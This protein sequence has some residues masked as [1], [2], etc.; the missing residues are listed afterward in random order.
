MGSRRRNRGTEKYVANKQARYLGMQPEEVLGLI[1][2]KGGDYYRSELFPDQAVMEQAEGDY[3][4][5][6]TGTAPMNQVADDMRRYYGVGGSESQVMLTNL[7]PEIEAQVTAVSEPFIKPQTAAKPEP[8]QMP[9]PKQKQSASSKREGRGVLRRAGEAIRSMDDAYSAKIAG[10]YDNANPTVRAAAYM[11]GGA[12][13]SFRKA[14]PDYRDGASD[15][16]RMMGSAAEYLIPAANAVPKYVLP[17]A[18]VTAA[19]HALYEVG[20]AL[21]STQQ[22]DGTVMP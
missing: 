18:G 7:P 8:R 17:A 15:M 19:G 12:H 6:R 3:S 4:T 22:S 2:R 10:M 5:F 13:P 9:A 16:E 11:V 20:Q 1:D 14:E 21:M